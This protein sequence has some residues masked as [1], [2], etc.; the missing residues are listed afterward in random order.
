MV[1][2]G[3]FSPTQLKKCSQVRGE[4]VKICKV[5]PPSFKLEDQKKKGKLFWEN[6]TSSWVN[7]KNSSGKKNTPPFRFGSK[8]S[9]PKNPG[10][11]S[12][13][14]VL[15]P[16]PQRTNFIIQ[17]N[18]RSCQGVS[19]HILPTKSDETNR[20]TAPTGGSSNEERLRR[21]FTYRTTFFACVVWVFFFRFS[22]VP[23]LALI[24]WFPSVA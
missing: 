3:G 23:Q 11:S 4:N 19:Q 21:F 22:K 17:G 13:S 12:K 15:P 24:Q 10:F 9:P 16:S 18:P 14:A 1:I 6:S 2:A 8:N 5:S 7:F 20:S